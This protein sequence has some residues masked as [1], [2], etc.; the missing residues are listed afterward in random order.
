MPQWT[1][2]QEAAITARG[3]SLVV[4][5]AAGSG[6]TAVLVERII[7]LLEDE[8]TGCKAE[9]MVIA[10]FTN[11]AA[12][13]VRQ[14]LSV[15]LT[16]R[17]AADPGNQWLRR[18]LMLLPSMQVSTIHSFCINLLRAQAASLHIS[19]GFR[20]MEPAEEDAL[21]QSVMS[22]ALD[23]VSRAAEEDAE[24]RTE[25]Q[26][27]IEAF[28]TADDA[29]LEDVLLSLYEMTVLT[30]FG[31]TLPDEAAEACENGKAADAAAEEITERLIHARGYYEYA[32][33]WNQQADPAI[34]TVMT[35]R[36]ILLD[37]IAFIDT[38]CALVK[39]HRFSEAAEKLRTVKFA[40]LRQDKQPDEIKNTVK[41]LRDRAKSMLT[42]KKRAGALIHW[43]EALQ[44]ADEDL[45]RHAVILRICGKYIRRFTELLDIE[46]QTRNALSFSDALVLALRLLAEK[47]PDGSIVKTPLAETLSQQYTCLMIDEFQDADNLKEMIFRMLSRGG[48]EEQYG[49]DLFVVG[50]SK[51][52][53]YRFLNANPGNFYRAMQEG[54]AYRSPALTE[55]TRID[56]NCNFRSGAEVIAFI[57]HVFTQLMTERVGEV[58]YDDSQKL[59]QGAEYPKIEGGRPVELTVLP[60]DGDE[61]AAVAARIAWHL[62]H[63]TPVKA[64]D[65][66][67][68]PCA[69]KDFLLLLRTS[70]H[71]KEYA[72]ALKKLGIPVSAIGDDNCL[73]APE[74]TLLLELLRAIDNPLLEVSVA[75]AMLSPMF[76]FSLDDVTAV[77]VYDRSASLF[78][79]MQKLCADE[80]SENTLREKCAAFLS[81]M[82]EMRLCSAMDTPEQLIRRIYRETDFLGMMQM[83]DSGGQKKANLRALVSYAHS[84]EENVGGGLSA[85][86]RSLD[87]VIERKGKLAGGSIPA[88]SVNAVSLKTIHGSKGL[89]APFVIVAG[90]NTRFSAKEEAKIC[91]RH[92]DVGIGFRLYDSASLSQSKTLPW[93]TIAARSKREALSEEMRLLY[94]ALTRAR[95]HLILPL[96]TDSTMLKNAKEFAFEQ[97]IFGGQTDLLTSAAGRMSDWILMALIRNPSCEALRRIFEAETDSDP[98]QPFLPL[99]IQAAETEEAETDSDENTDTAE[100]TAAPAADPALLETLQAACSW[101]YQNPLSGLTAKYGVSELSHHEDFSA[102]LRRPLFVRERRGLSGAERGTAVHTFLQ[103][104]D[105]GKAQAD[106]SAETTRLKA[107]GRLTE[108]QADAVLRSKIGDFFRDPIMARI[109]SAKQVWREQKFTVRLSDLDL[110]GDLAELGA[111]YAGTEGMLIGIMDLVFAEDDGIV[112]VDYKTDGVQSGAELLDRYTEQI[113]LYAEALRLLHGKPVKECCL[114]SVQLSKTV[115]VIL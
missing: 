113:R 62:E 93:M 108:K 88:A 31:E 33:A 14:R 18:Q 43:A 20:V 98:K 51:Q 104:A 4:S 8:E 39:E 40:T 97:S 3:A 60:E 99:C 94:V 19:S 96:V 25:Q 112:L 15:A 100:E 55:N 41:T 30:P 21:K 92:A 61:P 10:T 114:Y 47:Q 85:L 77:R 12:A 74:I 79:A 50:D 89:E 102:P 23:E 70:T 1:E 86:L 34:K 57:N 91:R 5:A 6:K 78:R 82:E 115:P 95:E 84:Y 24:I 109:R 110:T 52:C 45:R 54:A 29:P 48:T 11:D 56:L 7:R 90:L 9:N 17:A 49:D 46:K 22:A 71:M 42:D 73:N 27:L 63:R 26:T 36:G 72:D 68:V 67:M 58:K 111:Q 35:A 28:C 87:N 103:Y 80:N 16:K 2:M 83:R 69:P 81:F 53:I 75:S 101:Q 65:G 59:V 44:F 76:G 107:A 64:K 13:E 38:L 105:F 66:S 106:L 32:L 37:E